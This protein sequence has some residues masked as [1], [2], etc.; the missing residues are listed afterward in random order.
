MKDAAN[1]KAAEIL[2]KKDTEC[3]SNK[4]EKKIPKSSPKAG[5]SQTATEGNM[6]GVDKLK[7]ICAAFAKESTDEE[8]EEEKEN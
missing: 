2:G 5:P 1:N 7:Q 4:K 3:N 8:E 6:N